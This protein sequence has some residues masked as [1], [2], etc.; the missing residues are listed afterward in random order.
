[1]QLPFKW[2]VPLVAGIA[3]IGILALAAVWWVFSGGDEVLF[4]Q[5]GPSQLNGIAAELDRAGIPYHV[6]REKNAVAV[7]QQDVRSARLAVMSSGNALREAVGF[8]LFDKSDF[9]MT[10]FAQKIN[11]QRAMEGEIART[12]GAL[13]EIKYARVHLVLPEHNLFRSDKQRPRA[14]ITVFLNEGARLKAEQVRSVQRI[15][16]SAVPDLLEQDVTVV[17]QSGVTLSADAGALEDAASPAR[18]AQKKAVENYLAEKIHGVL[19]QAVGIDH[20]AV[21]VDVAV[22]YSRKTM[23]REKVLDAGSDAGIK[24]IKA[25]SSR[26]NSELGGEDNSKEVDYVLGR[27]SEQIVRDGGEVRRVQV[28]VVIDNGVQGVDLAKLSDLVAAAAGLDPARGDRVAVV[29]NNV[30]VQKALQQWLEPAPK[31]PVAVAAPVTRSPWLF[32]VFAGGLL[33]G[34]FGVAVTRSARRRTASDSEVD[35]LRLELRQWVASDAP[36]LERP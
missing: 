7:A 19:V 31:Q 20:F 24:R 23:T 25:S 27:E 30:A 17:N 11:Y 1:M 14:G 36:G 6:D 16:A 5:L 32:A 4:D 10:D 12:I 15:A 8:E 2:S 3:G 21:S 33:I 26:K 9:G 29:Q 28:G 13:E 34:G 22:D 18:L 35:R